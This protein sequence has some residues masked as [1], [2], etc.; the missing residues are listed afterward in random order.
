[1]ESWPSVPDHQG[2]VYLDKQPCSAA[3]AGIGPMPARA[4]LRPRSSG[5]FRL[6][7]GFGIRWQ[8]S[9]PRK[10]RHSTRTNLSDNDTHRRGCGRESS[11]RSERAMYFVSERVR[12]NTS[13]ELAVIWRCAKTRFGG[14]GKTVMNCAERRFLGH[15]H[16]PN[17]A[18]EECGPSSKHHGNLKNIHLAPMDS[19]Q[20][21]CLNGELGRRD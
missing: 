9:M 21:R 20:F 5:R 11:D 8:P 16:E 14:D 1:M 13:R 10:R 3:S 6:G 2:F 19:V 17:F 12:R 18:D 4:G 7:K 15:R